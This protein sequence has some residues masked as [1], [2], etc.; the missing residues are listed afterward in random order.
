VQG[1]E[2]R[3]LARLPEQLLEIVSRGEPGLSLVSERHCSHVGLGNSGASCSL[4]G[5]Y[6]SDDRKILR[7]ITYSQ[8]ELSTKE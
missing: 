3:V 7:D 5:T 1:A 8:S 6:V 4:N 2:V